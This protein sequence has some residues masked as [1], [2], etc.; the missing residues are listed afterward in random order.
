[1]NMP[2]TYPSESHLQL[3]GSKSNRK[4]IYSLARRLSSEPTEI[5]IFRSFDI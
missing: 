1:M 4:P 3:T 2:D 5:S